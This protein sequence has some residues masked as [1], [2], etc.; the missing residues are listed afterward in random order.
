MQGVKHQLDCHCIVP[1]I[2][3]PGKQPIYF[4][5]N[6]FSVIDDGN[7]VE[8]K[9]VQCPN[10]GV[11]HKVFDL[12]RSEILA[13]KDEAA[14]VRTLQDLKL[15]IPENL[16]EVL[17]MHNCELADFEK[18]EYILDNE[19]WDEYIILDREIED[20]NAVGKM[21]TF[22]KEGRIRIEPFMTKEFVS[23]AD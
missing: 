20:E 1:G 12:C 6:V 9:Y 19:K 10:C 11:I 21:L 15:S 5:F 18:L 22:R 3:G 13:G 17:E 4:K 14:M 16:V 8:L 7:N 2:T 23:A